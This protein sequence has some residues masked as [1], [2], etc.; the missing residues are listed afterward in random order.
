LTCLIQL[1]TSNGKEYVIDTQSPGVWDTVNGLAPI[2][3]NPDVVKIG[4]GIGGMDVQS[5]HRDFGIFVANA[6]DTHEAAKSLRM[7]GKGLAK[8]C[9]TYGLPNCEVYAEL[10]ETYQNTDW[11]RRPLEDPMILY[12]RHDVHYLIQLRRLMMRDLVKQELWSES[13]PITNDAEAKLVAESLASMISQFDEEENSG[14]E[15]KFLTPTNSAETTDDFQNCLSEEQEAETT[16][17]KSHFD[18]TELRMNTD[19]MQTISGSQEFCLK[20][21]KENAE[22]HLKDPEFQ[23]LIVRSQ[24]SKVGEWTPSQL[25]LYDNL[26]QWREETARREECTVGFICTM[27]FLA[28]IALKRPTSKIGL[29]QL[30]FTLPEFF[31]T[32][33][34]DDLLELVRKSRL[35]DRLHESGDFHIPCYLE[36]LERKSRRKEMEKVHYTLALT[37]G[38]VGVVVIAAVAILRGKR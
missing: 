33:N 14:D 28:L 2:F 25:E 17:R 35:H 38:I 11:S 37:V 20:L 22:S 32:N 36:F 9:A 12:G 15:S 1:A 24:N 10:K 4:H 29:L 27:G 18:V 30:S 26:A 21:W 5:L 19:L 3:A 34:I 13:N 23:S 8:I 16:E 6:F 31:Q 7:P